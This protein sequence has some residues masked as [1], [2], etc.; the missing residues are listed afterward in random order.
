MVTSAAL[1][2]ASSSARIPECVATPSI[3]A[4][5]LQEPL[6]ATVRPASCTPPVAL[7]EGAVRRRICAAPRPAPT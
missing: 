3:R 7:G 5:A 1:L 2:G 6:A 4:G